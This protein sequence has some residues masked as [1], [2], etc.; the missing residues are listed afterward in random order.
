MLRNSEIA[1]IDVPYFE[2]MTAKRIMYEISG[3]RLFSLYLPDRD[4]SS[5]KVPNR[6]YLFNVS[7][8]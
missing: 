8:E 7:A 2:E 4:A 5:K 3:S 1:I 6:K